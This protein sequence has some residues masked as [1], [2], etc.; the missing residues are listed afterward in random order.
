MHKI[1]ICNI[2]IINVGQKNNNI[3]KNSRLYDSLLKLNIPLV[4]FNMRM[5]INLRSG[6]TLIYLQFSEA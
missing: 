2:A 3:T 5:K 4:Q 1:G 6:K